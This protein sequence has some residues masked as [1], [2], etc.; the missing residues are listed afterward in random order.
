MQRQDASPRAERIAFFFLLGVIV[1]EGFPLVMTFAA[2]RVL[3]L[4]ELGLTAG[5][6]GTALAWALA[7]VVTATFIYLSVRRNEFIASHLYTFTRL[8][9]LAIPMAVVSGIFEE[10]FFRRFL[11]DWAMRGGWSVA[12]Q[13]ALS[14]V[15]FGVAHGIWGLF[16]GSLSAAAGA[17]IATGLLGL[18]LA[19]VYV[20]GGRA[21]APC[22]AS[23]TLIN[24]VLEPWLILVAAS[25]SWRGEALAD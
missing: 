23:H 22:A 17:T 9:A 1:V 12:A 5:H 3:F 2:N 4:L 16:G 25:G 19:V 24:L 8:K 10:A 6:R 18:A 11:M 21:V 20:V 13:I 15:I 7:L 14:A